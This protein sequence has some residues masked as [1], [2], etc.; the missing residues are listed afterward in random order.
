VFRQVV[1]HRW[2]PGID[3]AARSA[4]R[5]ALEALL[6]VPE[7]VA[8]RHGDDAAHFAGNHDYVAVLDFPDFAAARRYV[9]SPPHQAFVAEHARHVVDA[10]VVVQH[11]WALGQISGL[12]HVKLPVT[13]LARSR[14]WYR[15][16]F[17]F[18]PHLEF[19][20]RDRLC[21]VAL[22]HM[23]SGV[24]LALREDPARAEALAG[25]DA[26]C[27]AVGTR[28]DLDLLLARLD[29]ACVAHTPV[30]SGRGGDAVDVPDPDGHLIRL[31]TL[32]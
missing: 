19:R 5:S 26:V 8:M 13:D 14:E 1:A 2:A 20:E 23:A 30:V 29:S 16:A 11:D 21:G 18:E 17:G 7:L 12:H 24:V 25:F 31:H 4:Y 3:S 9:A 22:R 15:V 10:R 32:M 28:A 6:V 27:L